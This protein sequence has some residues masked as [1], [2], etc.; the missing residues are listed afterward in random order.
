M[1]LVEVDDFVDGVL[2]SSVQVE[3][4]R[5][6]TGPGAGHLRGEAGDDPFATYSS[7]I[8]RDSPFW[9]GV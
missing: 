9:D 3:A 8:I 5:E 4:S 6:P 1:R 7:L 2:S